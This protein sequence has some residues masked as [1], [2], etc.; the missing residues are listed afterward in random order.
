MEKDQ[1]IELVNEKSWQWVKD[2]FDSL[3]DYVPFVKHSLDINPKQWIDFSIDHF[4][5]AEQNYEF[6]DCTTELSKIISATNVK[7]GRNEHNSK[8]INYGKNPESNHK[9]L[10]MLGDDNLKKLD[11]LPKYMLC[12]LLV[13]FP[14]HGVAWHVDTAKSFQNYYPQLEIDPN[15]HK[16]QYG[17]VVRY[18]FPITN[19]CTGHIFQISNTVLWNY[20]K[21]QVYHIPFGQGHASSNAGF[22][23]QFSVSLTGILAS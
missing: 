19:W 2:Y 7:M 6:V 3:E 16:C 4:D 8:E 13:K 23:P 21:G 14:G 22:Q 5:Y 15:T 18:W 9:M 1:Y 11:L 12:R 10:D 20:K 17:Q